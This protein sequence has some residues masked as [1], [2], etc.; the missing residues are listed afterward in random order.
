MVKKAVRIA[1]RARIAAEKWR[2]YWQYNINNYHQMHEFVLG[3]QW[4]DEE[5][6]M[7]KTYKKVPLTFN[8]LGT[9]ANNL[10]GEQQQNTPQL[11][12]V[13]LQSCDEETAYLRELIVKD[14][15]FSSGAKTAYQVAASQ[16]AIG[17]FGAFLWD[18]AYAHN[19]SFDVDIVCRYF[20]DATLCY[21][22]IGAEH[23]NKIDGM[24]CGYVSR[25][26]RL[27]FRETFGKDLEE[28]ITHVDSISASEEEVALATDTNGQGEPFSWVDDDGITIQHHYERKFKKDT[29]YKLSNGSIYNQEEMDA[30]I[31]ESRERSL[32]MQMMMG[33]EAGVIEGEQKEEDTQESPQTFDENIFTL[34]DKGEPVRIVDSRSIKKSVIHYYKLAG[35]YIVE[36]TIFPAEDLPLIF[37]ASKSYYDK[38]GKQITKSFFEDAKDAQRYLNYLGTQSAYMLKVSR[39]DQWIGSKKNVSSNDTAQ[40]W[41]DPLSVQGMLIFDESPNG[42]I[43]QQ[44]RPPELSQSLLTQY[45]RAMNDLYTS[46]GLYPTRLGDT[47]NELSGAAID[48][49]TRQG[50]YA[51]YTFF[52]AINTAITTGGQ[53]VNDMIPVVYDAERVISLMT[54][55]EGQKTLVINRQ[56]DEYGEVIEND[57][58]KG[59]FEVRLVAGPSYEGQKAQALES[60][61]M[62]LQANPQLLNLFADL[63]AEN[64][65]L[66]NTIEIKNRLKTIVPPQIIEAGKTG[67]MP[68]QSG[69]PSPEEQMM[70]AQMQQQQR[71]Q[72]LKEREQFLREQELELKRQEIIL[73][74]Q[75]K[76]KELENDRLESAAQ[77]T[78][79]EL[80]YAAET[81][82]TAT[83]RHIAH[84]DNMAKILTHRI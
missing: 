3:K 22:D 26:T 13:P 77:L 67:R 56:V 65:P 73:D 14:L 12:V 80:R 79:T 78:E 29:L 21:W 84:A 11:Q 19:K 82:R 48:A 36:D 37:L 66:P 46:T 63:Y 69:Q 51:T 16:D 64:L 20:K 23:K 68:Q 34:Y 41:R 10:L 40:V 24:V 76:L 33:F 54:P 18:T 31:E 72:Q 43:P 9:L 75:L 1:K 71:E 32:R 45:E 61:N 53:I 38:N 47:G 44:T 81:E 2:Q 59:T 83:D 52:N 17:G 8:K 28:K 50:S 15:I 55:D 27:K 35:D 60:L 62:V 25:M 4:Q 49:R 7:L 42:V 57:I 70:Q 58:R 39:Y 6:N 30:L 5:E 74:A